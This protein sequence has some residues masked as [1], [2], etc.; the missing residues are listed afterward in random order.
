M[1]C[2][3]LSVSPQN[4]YVKPNLQYDGIKSRASEGWLDH[5][6]TAIM[7]RS[8]AHIKEMPKNSL[9]SSTTYG[10]RENTDVYEPEV[11]THQAPSQ[12]AS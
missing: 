3:S 5:E 2:H 8:V 12:P 4:S 9:F 11:G 6:G 10:L 1:E 7:R